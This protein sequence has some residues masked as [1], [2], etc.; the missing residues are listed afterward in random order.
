MDEKRIEGIFSDE[1]FVTRLLQMERVE[2]VQA[3]L[4]EKGLE[5]SVQDIHKIRDTLISTSSFDELSEA[6]LEEVAGGA[7]PVE[8]LKLIFQGIKTA[9]KLIS[10]TDLVS[11]RRW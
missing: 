3:A 5:L 10:T 4:K 8:F 6:D 2:E 1:A 7:I 11:N 9:A